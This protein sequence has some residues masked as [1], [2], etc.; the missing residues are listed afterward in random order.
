[1]GTLSA[2]RDNN[3]TELQWVTFAENYTASHCRRTITAEELQWMNEFV[4]DEDGT[5]MFVGDDGDTLVQ[6]IE[7]EL[8]I[9][10][11]QYADSLPPV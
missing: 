9:T 1:M 3:S 6:L 4:V 10:N 8:T 11:I 2:P 7:D 5:A